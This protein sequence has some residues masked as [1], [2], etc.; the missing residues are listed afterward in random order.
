MSLRPHEALEVL[1][2]VGIPTL[3]MHL[4]L[5]LGDRL[6]GDRLVLAVRQQDGVTDQAGEKVH[7]EQTPRLH[8][9]SGIS[10]PSNRRDERRNSL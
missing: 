4:L 7:D 3:L 2:V 8:G 10:Q 6:L 5:I 1:L 9:D